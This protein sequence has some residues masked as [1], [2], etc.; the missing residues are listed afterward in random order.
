MNNVSLIGRM[1]KDP[2]LRRTGNGVAVTSFT[3]AVNRMFKN[4]NGPDADFINVVV[5]NKPAEN[6][7]R[8][9]FKG[10]LVGIN[11]RLQTR[12]YDNN[13]GQKVYVTEVVA[14]S[15]QFL[16]SKSNSQRQEQPYQN[17]EN[18]AYGS[19]E[20]R[21]VANESQHQYKDAVYDIMQ[22]DIEF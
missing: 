3:L 1:T 12:N 18:N 10:S 8:Y 15:V 11:G 16:D 20:V 17:S 4:D 22:N 6:T 2:E 7:E 19:N 21:Q 5:W 14:E 9:C 13:Q